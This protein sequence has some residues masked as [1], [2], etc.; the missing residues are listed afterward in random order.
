MLVFAFRCQVICCG[1]P[2]VYESSGHKQR[3]RADLEAHVAKKSGRSCACVFRDGS[4]TVIQKWWDY[5]GS[6]CTLDDL[7]GAVHANAGDG[8]AFGTSLRRAFQCWC[9]ELLSH[10]GHLVESVL[11]LL[12]E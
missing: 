7:L 11:G 9:D 2:F 8:A 10:H 6:S 1:V 5:L 3:L 4:V 12:Q